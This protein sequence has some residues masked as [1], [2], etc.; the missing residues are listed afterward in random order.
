MRNP[1]VFDKPSPLNAAREMIRT[2]NMAVPPINAV[3]S[4]PWRLKT[5]IATTFRMKAAGIRMAMIRLQ[6]G[7]REDEVSVSVNSKGEVSTFSFPC[8]ISLFRKMKAVTVVTTPMIMTSGILAE[9]TSPIGMPAASEVSFGAACMTKSPERAIP[10]PKRFMAMAIPSAG[11]PT[12]RATGT[13][14]AP[15]RATAGD[16]QKNQ[17]M[18]IMT[19][20]IVQ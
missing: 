12:L 13:R 8:F 1:V 7:E 14:T 20:P 5:D 6:T 2:M 3:A 9:I 18:N 19:R 17:E 15:S 11:S 4:P 16:G 10:C